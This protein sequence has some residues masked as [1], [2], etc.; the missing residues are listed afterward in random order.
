MKKIYFASDFHLGIPDYEISLVRERLIVE[1]LEGI[2]HSA[3]EIYLMG[4]IFDF[5]H[6][7][8]S[9]V[10]KGYIRF[11]SKIAELTD[12][13]VT[14]NFLTGNHDLWTYGYLKQELGMNIY[15]KPITK[16]F[17]NKKFFLAH[18]DGLGPKDTLYKPMKKI[19]TSKIIQW[20]FANFIHPDIACRIAKIASGK[21][22][23]YLKKTIFK[24]EEE[25]LIIYSRKL[26][27][28]KHYDY[29]IYGHRHIP[30]KKELNPKSFY[31]GLGDW[32]KNFSYAVFDGKEVEIK[33]Y[34]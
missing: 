18:G 32:I 13:G 22:N 9:V 26:L 16:I 2:R 23:G 21:K 15:Y 3:K 11:L 20:C 14:I 28:K 7:W 6:E 34:K 33:K 24:D 4:D 8:K 1:W 10:P 17:N 19:F 31:I 5:W 27:E 25:W 29:L 12:S 30:I